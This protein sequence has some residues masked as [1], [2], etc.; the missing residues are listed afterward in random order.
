MTLIASVDANM[1]VKLIRAVK[2]NTALDRE[3]RKRAIS[4]YLVQRAV[5]MLPPQLCEELC[6]LVPDTERLAFSA[7]FEIDR[8]GRVTEKR[9]AKTIIQYVATTWTD[10]EPECQLI[11]Q[12][13]RQ[14][15]IC[16]CARRHLWRSACRWQSMRP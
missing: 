4:V 15:V 1:R 5:P 3:A 2:A 6:S 14:A 13:L 10:T 8:E 12:V 16:R 7:F 11:K 9:F